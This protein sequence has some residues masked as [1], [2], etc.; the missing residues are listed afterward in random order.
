MLPGTMD[1]RAKIVLAAIAVAICVGTVV[2][3]RRGVL[4]LPFMDDPAVS[5]ADARDAEEITYGPVFVKPTRYD[6]KLL[7]D[8][9]VRTIPI[10]HGRFAALLRDQP[11]FSIEGRGAFVSRSITADTVAAAKLMRKGPRARTVAFLHGLQRL[12]DE[13]KGYAHGVSLSMS[14][15]GFMANWVVVFVENGVF[16]Y[17]TTDEQMRY[18][19]AIAVETADVIGESYAWF[20][21]DSS[22]I[23]VGPELSRPLATY[24]RSP[25][26]L[27]TREAMTI[28]MVVRHELE[29]TVS[30]GGTTPR[31]LVWMEEGTAD[32]IALWP[33]AAATTARELG[34]PYPKRALDKPWSRFTLHSGYAR[35]AAT[36]RILVELGG[37]RPGLARDLDEVEDLLQDEPVARVPG[38][39]A[40]AIADEQGL[41]PKDAAWIERRIRALDGSPRKARALERDVRRRAARMS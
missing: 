2:G 5:S 29:H 38:V 27:S 36:L 3:V 41:A 34:L 13:R 11:R 4:L 32:V 15:D 21:F 35:W 24:F 8:R 14:H 37:V 22:W 18:L 23:V 9:R 16:N 17:A 40:K 1:Y 39:L 31:R 30:A 26:S 6:A 20:Q 19:V 12:M 25:K 10:G 28:A 33:G 7:K